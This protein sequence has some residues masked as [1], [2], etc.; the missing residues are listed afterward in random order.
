[1]SESSPTPTTTPLLSD[2]A[3]SALKRSATIILPAL[4]A[5][6]FALAQ[7]WHL[8]K[9]EEVVGSIA[10]VNTFVGGVVQVSKKSYYASGA[11]YAGTLVRSETADKIQY[12]L[13]LNEDTPAL[14]KLDEVTF[15]VSDTGSTPI[16][17]E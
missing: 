4:G 14:D 3:Y 13:E 9:A 6:Y 2:K 16:V 17:P 8:P 10:A 15:K 7:I 12:S 1:M 5:L 11:Q